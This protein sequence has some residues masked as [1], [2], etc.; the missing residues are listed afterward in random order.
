MTV[1]YSE[2]RFTNNE[3][4]TLNHEQPVLEVGYQSNSIFTYILNSGED[5][6]DEEAR[7]K[8]QKLGIN[9]T[10]EQLNIDIDKGDFLLIGPGSNPTH[11][12]LSKAQ[13]IAENVEYPDEKRIWVN[14]EA[15]Y[16]R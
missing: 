9:I 16:I 2:I 8:K 4:V 13:I 5:D 10:L 3:E 11:R 1:E 6:G 14:A 12:E 15:A 7:C